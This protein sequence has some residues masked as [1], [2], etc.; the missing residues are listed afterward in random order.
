[1]NPTKTDFAATALLTRRRV[2]S[3]SESAITTRDAYL[4]SHPTLPHQHIARFQLL[5]LL[6]GKKK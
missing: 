3:A 4:Q 5:M 1:M 2:S 6:L